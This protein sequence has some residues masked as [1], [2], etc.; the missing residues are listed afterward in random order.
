MPGYSQVLPRDVEI[1]TKLTKNITLNVPLLSAAMDTVT[2]AALATALAREGGLGILHKNMSIEKQA[3]QV[4]KVKRSESGL[5][6]DPVTLLAD[7]TIGDALKLMRENKIGGIPIIDKSGKLV[8]IL[9]NRDLRFEENM[10]R[11]VSEVMTKENLYTAP[12]GTDIKKAE[13]LFKKT[14]VEKLPIINKQGKLTGLF[15]Y[16]DILKLKSNPNAVKDKFGRLLVGAGVGITADILDRVAALQ[17]VGADVIALDSAHGHS[18]GVIEALKSVK[19]N[20]KNINVLAGNVGT[21]AGA[22]ALADAGADAIK[23]GIGPGSICTTRIVAGAGV[24]QLTAVME[25]AAALKG[26][27][28]PIIADGG[29][30]YTGDMVKALAAGADCVMMGSIFAGTEE[31]PG[32]TI[33]FE[34]R[35]FK[36]YRGMGSLGAMATGSSDRY[37]QDVEDDVKKFVPEGIEG[38]V[39]YKGTLKEIVYQ[40]TGGLRAGMGYCGAGNIEALKKAVFVKITNAGMR[41]SHAHDI[42]ITKE[43]PNYSRK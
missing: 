34:G 22:K 10:K 36:Q 29:I 11:K 19:K 6:I 35:K 14:K 3:E 42:E 40:Y 38:R 8:G 37:F 27:N 4:R 31:S 41:E 12:E 33:I 9:T 21:A 15:T 1:K 32:E 7:A 5:I 13:E 17:T 30:R 2:E 26:K 24:P 39:A 20:F 28:I 16:S 43:A 23:V 18:K 25:A